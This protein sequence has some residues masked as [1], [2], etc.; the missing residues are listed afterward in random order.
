MKTKRVS[1]LVEKFDYYKTILI[2]LW[3]KSI[4]S[5]YFMTNL[6]STSSDTIFVSTSSQTKLNTLGLVKK[7]FYGH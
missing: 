5:D 4:F 1:S 7:Y 3:K 6:V 2:I